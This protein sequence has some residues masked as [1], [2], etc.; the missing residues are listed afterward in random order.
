MPEADTPLLSRRRGASARGATAAS[1]RVSAVENEGAR[2]I[3]LSKGAQRAFREGA[4]WAEACTKRRSRLAFAHS[5]TFCVQQWYLKTSRLKG[6][7][8][9]FVD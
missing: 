8:K 5:R 4:P 1:P 6:F 7:L 3:G 9:S 2:G